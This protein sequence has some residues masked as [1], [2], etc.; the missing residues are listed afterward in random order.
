MSTLI[1]HGAEIVL[2][3]RLGMKGGGAEAGATI[4]VFVCNDSD[5]K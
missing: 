3:D 1:A 2:D 4:M 5:E